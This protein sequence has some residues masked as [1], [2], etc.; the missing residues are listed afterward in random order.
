MLKRIC[1]NSL[2]RVTL[3]VLVTGQIPLPH[4]ALPPLPLLCGRPDP[5]KT[6]CKG[7]VKGGRGCLVGRVISDI[8]YARSR[9]K[10]LELTLSPSPFSPYMFARAGGKVPLVQSAAGRGFGP[11]FRGLISHRASIVSSAVLFS[12]PPPLPLRLLSFMFGFSR[13]TAAVV[14]CPRF[15]RLSSGLLA[16]AV[17]SL[18]TIVF[19]RPRV[20]GSFAFVF[21]FSPA[22]DHLK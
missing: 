15:S 3:Y 19:F 12:P 5:Q 7:R 1:E 11:R 20:L 17:V 10:A 4:F 6:L 18:F 8:I 9:R 16:V 21:S 13:L 14:P 22:S 2:P